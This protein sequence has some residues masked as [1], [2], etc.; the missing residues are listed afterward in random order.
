MRIKCAW[1]P[2]A[3][4]TAVLLVMNLAG[5]REAVAYPQWQF[6]AGAVRCN[7]CHFNPA[8]GG[9]I[10]GYGRDKAGEELST[11]EGDGSFAHGA[12]ELPS[13]LALGF[14][15]RFAYVRQ[16]NQSPRGTESAAFPMQADVYGRVAMGD[17]FSVYASAG[18][19]GQVRNGDATNAGSP[20]PDA[21]AA[22]VSREHYLMWRPRPVGVYVRAGRF[23]APFGLRLAEH[24]T[25]VRRDLGFNQ[26]QETYNVSG[27]WVKDDWELHA[28]LF[29][30]DVLRHMGGQDR[31]AAVYFERRIAEMAGIALQGRS[32]LPRDGVSTNTAG[33]VSKVWIEPIKTM[34]LAEAN[35]V[36]LSSNKWATR[37]QFVGAAGLS[38]LPFK[39]V[40]L[41]GLVER[42]QTDLSVLDSTTNAIGGFLNWFP[43]PHFELQ[44]MGR[45]Q[46]PS[47]P[48]SESM[49]TLFVQVHYYL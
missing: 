22:F 24:I 44:V 25:Y 23:Y 16:D 7:Q 33:T 31:G 4:A 6:S 30:P 1:W 19:R 47:G 15:G 42:R 45:L 48:S 12:L 21:S 20:Q 32:T 10:N 28:T 34:L 11:F 3:I 49:K 37:H 36:L 43:Y 39:G 41:T 9:L 5:A 14:D 29:A 18:Y 26:L 38:V 8:G 27:G 13:W 17:S 46:Q 35:L 2:A 40:T